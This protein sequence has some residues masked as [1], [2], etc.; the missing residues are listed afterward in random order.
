MSASTNCRRVPKIMLLQRTL[1]CQTN[2]HIIWLDHLCANEILA[3]LSH[4]ILSGVHCYHVKSPWFLVKI[5]KQKR[6]GWKSAD[7]M[8]PPSS[9]MCNA[10]N[11]G[12]CS[13]GWQNLRKSRCIDAATRFSGD[14]TWQCHVLVA[15]G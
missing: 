6:L 9:G 4:L 11:F 8:P 15:R 5:A 13:E 3:H 12:T 2:T 10:L 7:L 14:R 1:G